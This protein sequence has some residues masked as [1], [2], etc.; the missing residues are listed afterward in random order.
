MTNIIPINPYA[1]TNGN[2]PPIGNKPPL[3]LPS[4]FGQP[5]SNEVGGKRAIGSGGT[6][7]QKAQPLLSEILGIRSSRLFTVH[8]L[9]AHDLGDPILGTKEQYPQEEELHV[10]FTGC[11][12]VVEGLVS[13]RVCLPNGEYIRCIEVFPPSSNGS[14]TSLVIDNGNIKTTS[15]ATTTTTTT[16]TT[17]TSPTSKKSSLLLDITSISEIFGTSYP[18]NLPISVT[19]NIYPMRSPSGHVIVRGFTARF[20]NSE[21]GVM[22]DLDLDFRTMVLARRKFLRNVMGIGG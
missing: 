16:T 6:I 1:N 9:L 7:P 18:T 22:P 13:H 20:V 10:A 5:G 12:N 4:K 15:N 17:P 2:K 11:I 19:G 3:P 21:V 8:E 14:T